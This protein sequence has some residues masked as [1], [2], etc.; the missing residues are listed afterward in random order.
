MITNSL[1][2]R[3]SFGRP[4]AQSAI[5]TLPHVVI[6]AEGS[7]VSAGEHECAVCKDDLEHAANCRRLPCN[8][9]YHSD[10][11]L[12]WLATNNSCPVCRFELPVSTE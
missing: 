9:L 12:P 2:D 4:T 11:I 1:N 6:G 7:G 5:D 10:C 8:H 3:N